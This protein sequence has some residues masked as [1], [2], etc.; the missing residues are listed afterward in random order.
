M[1]DDRYTR[2]TLRIPKDLHARLDEEAD[3][4][5]KS[6]NAEIIARL[7]QSFEP[8][9]DS[10]TALMLAKLQRDQMEAEM[11]A[12]R[13]RMLANDVAR[14]LKY[15]SSAVANKRATPDEARDW[16]KEAEGAL[17]K[18]P[19][20]D[21]AALGTK[22]Q[23][24]MDAVARYNEAMHQMPVPLIVERAGKGKAK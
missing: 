4:T 1:D 15:A 23:N 19:R 8:K 9:Q 10:V 20:E 12:W 11:E 7:Q 14:V 21:M 2:I 3:R 22:Y 16:A 17:S 5:S 6:L 13:W 24:L 18:T